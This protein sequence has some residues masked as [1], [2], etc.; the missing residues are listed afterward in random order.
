MAGTVSGTVKDINLR[1]TW[2]L[3]PRQSSWWKKCLCT[4]TI[5]WLNIKHIIKT[6][7]SEMLEGSDERRI[8]SSLRNQ[9]EEQGCVKDD[10]RRI[11]RT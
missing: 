2:F 3:L 9:W 5:M 4:P 11:Y 10:I 6:G 7:T 1:K 8:T